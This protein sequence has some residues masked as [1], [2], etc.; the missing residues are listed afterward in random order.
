VQFTD[1][2]ALM[3]QNCWHTDQT[4][5]PYYD[6]GAVPDAWH[7]YGF[8]WDDA[9]GR[10]HYFFDG[11]HT[12]EIAVPSGY[13]EPMFAICSM[14]QGGDW[15][16][17]VP[18]GEPMGQALFD[19]VRISENPPGAML[20]APQGKASARLPAVQRQAGLGATVN[21][22]ANARRKR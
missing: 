9:N 13:E 22:P 12:H 16:G 2:S 1:G 8:W 6:F 11:T 4:T 15:S 5:E 17:P 3:A 21:L 10:M 18:D 19:Y 20:S 7:T 14:Q